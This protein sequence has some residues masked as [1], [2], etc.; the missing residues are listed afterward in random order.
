MKIKPNLFLNMSPQTTEEGGLAFARN[1]KLDDDGNLISDYGYKNITSMTNYNIVGH[2]V[3]LD[4]K[5]YFFCHTLVENN[6]VD[7][8]VEYDEVTET[9]TALTTNWTYGGGEIDGYVNTNQSGEKILTIGEYLANGSS[10]PL[11][12]INLKFA[13]IGDQTFYS[14][15]PKCPTANLV[16][17]DT[18]VKTIPNG[19]Y[20]FFIR[21]KIRKDVYTNW[22]LCSRPIFGGTSEKITTLQG[23]LS[24]INYHKDSAKSFV[25][26]LDFAVDSNKTLYKEFQLGFIIS[27]DEATDARMW[28]HFDMTSFSTGTPGSTANLIYFD[29]EDVEEANI[30]DLLETTYELYN[31][32][33]VTAFKNKLYISNYIESNFNPDIVNTLKNYITLS[34]AHTKAQGSSDVDYKNM[35]YNATPLHYDYSKGYY[36]QATG[37]ATIKSLISAN[38]FNYDV[39][40]LAKV[41]SKEKTNVARFDVF[42]NA[43]INPDIALVYNI[44]NDLHNKVIFGQD[45]LT[46]IPDT[47]GPGSFPPD[48]AYVEKIANVGLRLNDMGTNAY[49]YA[50]LKKDPTES[51]AYNNH[52]W[53]NLGFTFGFGSF[54][55]DEVGTPN[56]KLGC[57]LFN[58]YKYWLNYDYIAGRTADFDVNTGWFTR[59]SG[60]AD[61]ARST[62]ENTVQREIEDRSF[63]A[64]AYLEIASGANTYLI[65]YDEEMDLDNYAGHVMDFNFMT[66]YGPAW[67]YQ[68][69][70][71]KYYSDVD[72]LGKTHLEILNPELFSTTA[73]S[74]SLDSKIKTWV[75]NVIYN[76]I[77][78]VDEN[79]APV[80]NVGTVGTP[81]I[82]RANSIS[83]K[84][85]KIDFTVDNE[86]IDTTEGH[87]V[88]RFKISMKTTDYTSLCTFAIKNNYIHVTDN[89]IG[90]EQRST[91]MPLSTYQPYV[92]FVD[93]HNIVTN[94]VKLPSFSTGAANSNDDVLYLKYTV[95]AN[96]PANNFKSFF[97]SLVSIGDIVMEGFGYAKVPNSTTNIV[98]CLE[99]DTLLY[100]INDNITVKMYNSQGEL[101]RTFTDARYYSSGSSYPPLAFGNCGFIAFEDGSDWSDYKIYIIISRN[102]SAENIDNLP[103]ASSYIPLQT[104]ATAKELPDGY[105]GSWLS[106][107]KKPSF[108][109]SSSCYVSGKDVYAVNRTTALALTEFKSFIQVQDSI[110][111]FVRSNFNLNY[112]S[113]TEDIA[114]SIFTVGSASSGVKQVARVIN[115]AILSF[116]YELKPMYKD[117][118]NK[119]FRRYDSDYKIDFDNTVRVS[120]VLSD[121]TFNNSVFK[122]AATDYYNIP[123]DRGII[124]NLF[125]IGNIIFV[126]TKDSFYKFDGN[127]TIAASNQDI[128][129]Q[130]SEP[131]ETGVSQI[132]DS[133][134]GYG[135]I[136][137]K[138]SGC[139]T[140]DSYFFYDKSSNHIFAYGGNSQVQLID[141][142]IYKLLAYYKP[143]ECKTL[144]DEL[145]CR[146]LFEFTSSRSEHSVATYKTFTLSYN[147]KTKTFVSLHDLSLVNAFA[148]RHRAYSYKNNGIINTLIRLFE[149]ETT[150]NTTALVAAM[151]VNSIFGNATTAC[152]IE[153]GASLYKK[154]IAPFGMAI[155][156][157]PREN[158][159]ETVNSIKYIADIQ[160]K[161]PETQSNP[162]FDVLVNPQVSRTNPVVNFYIVTDCC[163]SSVVN[164]NVNDNAR[165]NTLLDYKGFK[166]DMGAWTSNYFR[167]DINKTDIYKYGQKYPNR[168]LDADQ[169]SLVYGRYFII[170]F[171]FKADTPVKFEELFMNTEKY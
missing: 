107:V 81:I 64:K 78:G 85:K 169:N 119:F 156:M 121:E 46:P 65:D 36:D 148:G 134:Y 95:A 6:Y 137:T 38:H 98:H 106:F 130:E 94:G 10:I 100:N 69:K 91:L 54:K 13:T 43:D 79:G 30:D 145:N 115:S 25:L 19:V 88:K 75:Y 27:H 99:V 70:P 21:Y 9:A 34:V 48:P 140:F 32:R 71:W 84:F 11:K 157:F 149:Y 4:N 114:D 49:I 93:E 129:L 120:H 58:A 117:F 124:V 60:F 12:H 105:Y 102:K 150:I 161:D 50:P 57:S 110:T 28:K 18:Y 22:F 44:Y 164:T 66:A 35:T 67:D 59:D 155:V 96:R 80:L 126:H 125:S 37:G 15:A 33:N 77:V 74:A 39:T 83:V 144:H 138:Q 154:Q 76:K 152:I 163:V 8:I 146:V 72:G 165:P 108:E 86:D 3:G 160:Q 42:W 116:I 139:I 90:A 128:Q 109:L 170:I 171:D 61:F 20:I 111:Y 24:Y 73:M 92:H 53:Y 52:P 17:K 87:Y 14:Q 47:Y 153:F 135:G 127:Q 151:N 89:G 143:S 113:L 63:F 16:L 122:F 40:K 29:Y 133:E 62:I 131:F 31:V 7:K 51:G 68:D 45:W 82:V 1:M 167:N 5:V 103:K 123:T 136:D 132:F 55:A 104:E 159:R 101:H 142:N 2:I 56:Y 23:G 26:Q 118:A 166:F 162:V 97:I 141:G 112:L 41:E 147:Y 158:L 168:D